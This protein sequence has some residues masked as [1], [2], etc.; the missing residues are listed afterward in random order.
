MRYWLR[1]GFK[2]NFV[3]TARCCFLR[4]WMSWFFALFPARCKRLDE[5]RRRPPHSTQHHHPRP[6]S[7]GRYRWQDRAT[8]I[9]DFWR[10][11][12]SPSPKRR[13]KRVFAKKSSYPWNV[14]VLIRPCSFGSIGGRI[15]K[16]SAQIAGMAMTEK[17]FY[18]HLCDSSAYIIWSKIC[19]TV[20]KMA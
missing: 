19:G 1:I 3:S 16:T 8:K 11:R 14:F 9:V 20:W 10:W 17:C 15:L 18:R 4:I 13:S 6:E 7:I 2:T 5:E 12:C